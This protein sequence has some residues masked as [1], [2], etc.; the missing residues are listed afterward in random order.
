MQTPDDALDKHLF[1]QE[2]R[3]AGKIA[4]IRAIEGEVGW[5]KV[6]KRLGNRSEFLK[7]DKLNL[8]C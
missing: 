2:R 5:Q 6:K 8:C 7:E 4:F 3:I 1:Y